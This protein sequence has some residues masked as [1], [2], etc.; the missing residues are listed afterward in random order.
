LLSRLAVIS[1]NVNRNRAMASRLLVQ[2]MTARTG[3]ALATQSVCATSCAR[4]PARLRMSLQI[5]TTTFL[6]CSHHIYICKSG[7]YWTLFCL[8]NSFPCSCPICDFCSLPQGFSSNFLQIPPHERYPCSWLTIPTTELVVNFHH[9][10]VVDAGRTKK[11]AQKVTFE[12][13]IW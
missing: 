13:V 5:R 8:A 11:T 10:V 4:S 3:S 1:G 6:L 2:S 7:Y 12:P 9:Q